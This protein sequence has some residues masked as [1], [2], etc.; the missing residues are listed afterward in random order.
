MKKNL[1]ILVICLVSFCG[2][3][4]QQVQLE[5]TPPNWQVMLSNLN[6]SQITAGFLY[7]K[8]AMFTNLY[9]FNR[10]NYNISHKDHF[11][12]A[13]NELYY[14]SE[15][16]KF[17]SA[18]QLRTSSASTPAGTI[19]VGIINS[20]IT[21]LNFNEKD[22]A[23]S[24]LTFPIDRFVPISGQ[25]AFLTRKILLASPLKES[26]TGTSVIYKFSAPFIF[27]NSTTT[28]KTLVVYFND[29]TP[30][31]II[32]NG[33]LVLASK[34]VNYTT[35]GK[36]ALKF[37][38]TFIDNSTITT[39]GYHFFSYISPET[40]SL[41]ASPTT[42]NLVSPCNYT[43][44]DRDR[45]KSNIAFQGYDETIAYYGKFDRTVFYHTKNPDGSVNTSQRKII[46]PIIIIDGF[47]PGDNR[48]TTDCDCEMDTSEGG[49]FEK[50]SKD[51]D[52]VFNATKHE[53]IEDNMYY[54]VNGQRLNL[55]EKLRLLGYDVIILNIPNYI[56][57]KETDPTGTPD[58]YKIDGGADYVERNG[59]ALASYLKTIKLTLNQNGSAEDIVIM[60]PSMGGL[61]SRYA[62][63]YMEKQFATTGNINWKHN[64]RVWVSFDSPHLGANIPMGAQANIWFFGEKL[65]NVSAKD[66]FDNQLN[67]IAGKQMIINQFSNTLATMSGNTGTSSNAPFFTQFQSNLN[68]NGIAGS[69]GFPT[70]TSTFRKIAIVNGSLS[71]TKNG[72]EGGEFLNI[73][74]YKD[75]TILEGAI[76]GA[77]LGYFGWGGIGFGA[78]VGGLLGASNA[79]ITV[80]RSKDNFYPAYGQNNYIFQGDGQ[81][82]LFNV[83][84][85]HWYIDFSHPSYRLKGINH[86]NRGSLDVVPAGTFTT[87][88]ILRDEI[89]KGVEDVGL[90]TEV[91]GT[92]IDTHS[93][94]PTFSSLA[95]LNPFQN[96]SNPLNKNL[97]CPSNKLTPFDSYYGVANNTLHISLTKEMVDWLLKELAGQQQAPYFPIE[98]NVLN[99]ASSICANTNTTYTINDVCKV[100]SPVMYTENGVAINGWSVQGNL[101]IVS[102][103]PYSISVIGTS[104][105]SNDATI[106]A[107]FQN[108]QT[109]SI[110][111]HIG[112]PKALN[113]PIDNSWDW[114]CANS[115]PF[116][117]SVTP[118]P[119]ATSYYW[120]A[121]ADTSDFPMVCPP[122][123]QHRAVF[124]V[125]TF[126]Y[127]M[128]GNYYTASTPSISPTA[129]I[130]WGT[131]LGSYTLACYAT[132]DCGS[133]LA[134]LIKY[135]TVGKPADNPCR[136]KVLGL[137]IAPN[138]VISGT[139][140]FVVSKTID[141]SPCNYSQS[142]GDTPILLPPHYD[143][144]STLVRIFD[145]QGLEV[146]SN[147]F[148]EPLYVEVKELPKVD[149]TNPDEVRKY[150]ELNHFN[151]QNIDLL[152]GL[153]IINV[154]S[155][156]GIESSEHI[157]VE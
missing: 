10:G 105:D 110:P 73:R 104:D 154:K 121:T 95:H 81:N 35:S 114:V 126:G 77:V 133:T 109:T 108:G 28:L 101:Q 65:Y 82:S 142:T 39:V 71:G 2:V 88:K 141:Y 1:F 42:T 135:T 146:Y 46:K 113:T 85:N 122:V 38:A 96:W 99:G 150:E 147:E 83:G 9:D 148:A 149:E 157:I 40:A 11:Y 49:C 118:A 116:P 130:N 50:Y 32:N 8:V 63:A 84:F 15:Q 53:S 129:T 14:A 78:I 79:N 47:D 56:T 89:V 59:L 48:K 55:I 97:T 117:M 45:Y 18:S 151:I 155:N 13:I 80:L 138:P 69:S 87:G 31:T 36:K 91:R 19:D 43:L 115:G 119:F 22:P 26:A 75:P 134:Y 93:F 128:D 94:I 107:T 12:Q 98:A 25:P 137:K 23:T 139:T 51:N 64:T 33:N 30:V 44:K 92:N 152:P 57:T 34:T 62:L 67:S 16:T 4:A 72:V 112:A 106:T 41:T 58:Y 7:N 102:S 153:Y 103:T 70:S 66:K 143:F 90:S 37:V 123:N 52:G 120:V 127:D 144:E 5:E 27:N 24:G 124:A 140:N 20:T 21:M 156:D 111:V 100:P 61:I 131:C 3:K 6:Q 132:N 145:Y 76:G 54:S 68:S 125:G 74:G 60:G 136:H 86:D 29:A 17:I